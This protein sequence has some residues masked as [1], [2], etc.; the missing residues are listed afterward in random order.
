MKGN[1]QNVLTTLFLAMIVVGLLAY[2]D[3][4][5]WFGRD[6]VSTATEAQPDLIAHD[7][8]QVHF[9]DQGELN[10]RLT[11]AEMLQFLEADHNRIIQPD[12]LFYRLQV[13]A[14]K[15]TADEGNSDAMGETLHLRG[16][17]TIQ[18]QGEGH[19]AKLET[20]T[21]TLYPKESKAETD[22]KVTIHQQGIFI[23]ANGLEAD[24]NTNQ[25]TL[26]NQVTS[27]YEPEKS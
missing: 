22:D 9:D 17:V 27:I 20:T 15:T 2:S 25:L 1:T 6:E 24:L 8:E 23:E 26:K 16:H 4:D 10:Y 12:I 7:V 5:K 13:P 21:L 14:W 3:W 18:Q 19:L 11:A